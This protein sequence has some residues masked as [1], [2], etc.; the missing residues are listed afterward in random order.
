MKMLFGTLF[1]CKLDA[2]SAS[3]RQPPAT[4]RSVGIEFAALAE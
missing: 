4:L 1:L 2:V 3:H